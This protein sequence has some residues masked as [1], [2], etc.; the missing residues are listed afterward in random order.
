MSES[1]KGFDLEKLQQD[2]QPLLETWKSHWGKIGNL[3][4]GSPR[5]LFD[6]DRGFLTAD[7]LA[8]RDPEQVAMH[9]IIDF[10]AESIIEAQKFDQQNEVLEAIELNIERLSVNSTTFFHN[11]MLKAIFI[12]TLA[13][14]KYPK[15]EKTEVDEVRDKTRVQFD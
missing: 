2:L 3:S 15:K 8:A 14:M 1:P 10:A 12:R 11:F 13:L 9:A 4:D 6:R 5:W 7:Q